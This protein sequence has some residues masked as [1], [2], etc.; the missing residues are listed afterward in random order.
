MTFTFD[1]EICVN[2]TIFTQM[3]CLREV[4]AKK[5]KVGSIYALGFFLVV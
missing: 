5:H 4:E 2:D 1:L 3:L